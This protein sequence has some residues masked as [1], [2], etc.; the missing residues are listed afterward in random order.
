MS[1]LVN[2][3]YSDQLQDLNSL[4]PKERT[5]F[6]VIDN[7]I[8]HWY[9]DILKTPTLE[10]DASEKMKSF[11]G[12][13]SITRFL[14]ENGADRSS[15]LVG[16]GGGTTT[17]LV[18]FCAS[19]YMRGIDCIL[20]PTTL[21]AQTDA[22]IGGK[23]GINFE[24][25]KNVLG[26][27]RQPISTLICPQFLKTLNKDELLEG[28]AEML[29]IFIICDPS[30]FRNC[31][32]LAI[33]ER[34]DSAKFYDL[35]KLAADYKSQIVTKDPFEKGERILLNLGHTF[36]H[37]YEKVLGVSHGKAVAA[38]II[39]AS[40][41]S[42][43]LGIADISMANT[44]LREF[45][46]IGYETNLIADSEKLSDAILKDKKKSSNHIQFI[47]PKSI[48][49]VVVQKIETKDLTQMFYDLS[50]YKKQ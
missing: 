19:I 15:L 31:A 45:T 23:N 34:F 32:D 36:A 2:I 22:A 11:S 3:V 40:F 13:D 4:L 1:E 43:M 39:D 46:E 41:L 14:L 49:N 18:A 27:I 42:S 29:K 8:S 28:L 47:L 5:I 12:V 37:A 50:K 20:V 48:G 7:N 10:I 30:A 6:T 24:G 17:D 16:V 35:V 21:L 44:I 38:G 26:T 33:K 9:S 25:Y